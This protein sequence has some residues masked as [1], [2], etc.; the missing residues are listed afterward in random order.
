MNDICL[1]YWRPLHHFALSLGC[2]NEDAE[3][4]VQGFLAKA[5]GNDFF[6]NADPK[7]GRM[8]SYLLVAFR[9]YIYDDWKKC[10]ALRRG[11]NAQITPLKSHHQLSTCADPAL[12]FDQQWAITII[13]AAKKNLKLRYHNLGKDLHFSTLE[14]CIDGSSLADT[15]KAAETLGISTATLKTAVYRIRKRYGEEV[16]K[17]VIETVANEDEVDDE[18]RWLIKVLGS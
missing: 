9:R 2:S 6:N 17:A 1:T 15:N 7:R 5:G 13:E 10:Q 14:T 18:L 16:R 4:C 3:D 11:G 8:R 12:I